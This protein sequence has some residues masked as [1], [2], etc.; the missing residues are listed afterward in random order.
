M[1]Y[2]EVLP[3]PPHCDQE[4]FVV[5]THPALLHPLEVPPGLADFTVVV[6]R[7][8][9]DESLMASA[10]LVGVFLTVDQLKAD[11]ARALVKHVHPEA[12]EESRLAM[13]EAIMGRHWL[14]FGGE[15]GVWLVDSDCIVEAMSKALGLESQLKDPEIQRWRSWARES[16]VRHVTLNINRSL[17]SAW[18]GYSY[19]DSFDPFRWSTSSF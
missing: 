6:A 11:Y 3:Q 17:A 7:V 14:R 1:S 9:A 4:F 18:Q 16:L 12:S 10:L 5:E 13:I 15:D 19:I 2:G 8:G